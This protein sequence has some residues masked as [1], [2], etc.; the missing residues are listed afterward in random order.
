METNAKYTVNWLNTERTKRKLS[1]KSLGLAAKFS[2]ALVYKHERAG[3]EE[4]TPIQIVRYRDA[5]ESFDNGTW[6]VEKHK[7]RKRKETRKNK[8]AGAVTP[9][10]KFKFSFQKT[11]EVCELVKALL[12]PHADAKKTPRFT[13]SVSSS[14]GEG[15]SVPLITVSASEI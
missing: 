15:K 6:K 10:Q 14:S 4:L 5:F 8:G 13:V 7:Y 1:L 3:Q 12:L 11:D 2:T 9:T